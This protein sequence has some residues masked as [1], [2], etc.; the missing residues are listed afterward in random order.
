M[1]FS[2]HLSNDSLGTYLG[3]GDVMASML[4]MAR[5]LGAACGALA[6]AGR[7]GLSLGC[8]MVSYLSVSF[9]AFVTFVQNNIHRAVFKRDSKQGSL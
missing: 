7:L 6:G 4:H 3:Q 1:G 2:L 8:R 9:C 5:A